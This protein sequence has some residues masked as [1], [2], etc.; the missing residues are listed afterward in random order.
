VA[1]SNYEGT[2]FGMFSEPN[3]LLLSAP[4]RFDDEQPTVLQVSSDKVTRPCTMQCLQ[5][6]L[7]KD[8]LLSHLQQSTSFHDPMLLKTSTIIVLMLVMMM[9]PLIMI[10]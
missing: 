7:S 4:I 8:A 1:I 5:Q 9:T 3:H 6:L 2:V 10:Y